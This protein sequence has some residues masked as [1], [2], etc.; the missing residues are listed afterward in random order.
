MRLVPNDTTIMIPSTLAVQVRISI[1][2]KRQDLTRL[3]NLLKKDVDI[4]TLRIQQEKRRK[5]RQATEELPKEDSEPM[6]KTPSKKRRII[7]DD[8]DCYVCFQ[9]FSQQS[10]YDKI[11]PN[12]PHELLL[13]ITTVSNITEEEVSL[14]VLH[15]KISYLGPYRRYCNRF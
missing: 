1:G 13:I 6:E 10:R 8:S 11:E 15:C 4:L 5:E 9:I 7:L 3:L 14:K 2:N 12:A